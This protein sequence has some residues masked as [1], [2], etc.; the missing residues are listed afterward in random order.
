MLTP[1][2][3]LMSQAAQLTWEAQVVIALRLMRLASGGAAAQYEASGMI[4][5]K[6]AALSAA[7][8]I[9]TTSLLGDGNGIH[10]M[11]EVL[12]N[13]RT[14]VRANKRRLVM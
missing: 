7:H 3:A 4:T 1:W 8:P 9:A 5:E 12:N 6:V 2:L 14:K 13:Y 10:A 11:E